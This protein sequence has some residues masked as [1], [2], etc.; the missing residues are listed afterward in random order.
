LVGV[1]DQA[2]STDLMVYPNPTSEYL[3][4]PKTENVT[5]WEMNGKLLIEAFNVNAINVASLS[6]GLYIVKLNDSVQVFEKLN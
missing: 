5:V 6:T 3:Y 4:F 1:N 2:L